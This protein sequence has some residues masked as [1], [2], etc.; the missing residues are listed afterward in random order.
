VEEFI[1]AQ[2]I[3]PARFLAAPGSAQ[4]V[5]LFTSMFMHG[6]WL[7]LFSNM[8][9]LYIFGDNVEDRLGHFGYLAFYLFCGLAAGLIHIA[10]NSSSLLPTIG[11]SGAISGVL[12]AYFI[13]FPRARV[14]TLVPLFILPWIIEI[15]ALFYLGFWFVSQ[16]FNGALAIAAGGQAFSGVAF[17]AHV[18]GFIAGIILVGLFARRRPAR[19]TYLDEYRPW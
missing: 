7:H 15:P 4:A 19:R 10:F 6:G 16:L 18:G 17:W 13:L 11:A 8:L 14:I 9:A 2:G 12:G 1:A 5:T 3:V